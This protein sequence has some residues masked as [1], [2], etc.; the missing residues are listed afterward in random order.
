[1]ICDTLRENELTTS[2]VMKRMLAETAPERSK[3]TAPLAVSAPA[4]K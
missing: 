4:A 2:G 3:V 1:L